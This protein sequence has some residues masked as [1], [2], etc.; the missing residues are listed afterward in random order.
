[1]AKGRSK[2]CRENPGEVFPASPLIA[3][4][5]PYFAYVSFYRDR[6]LSVRNVGDRRHAFAN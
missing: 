3:P 5:A 4:P 2:M 1:M 6:K